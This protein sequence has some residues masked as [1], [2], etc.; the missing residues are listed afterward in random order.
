MLDLPYRA[1]DE[2]RLAWGAKINV[3]GITLGDGVATGS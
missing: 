1:A 2:A 3:L